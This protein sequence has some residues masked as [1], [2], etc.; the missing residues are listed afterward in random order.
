MWECIVYCKLR[1]LSYTHIDTNR[2]W[3]TCFLLFPPPRFLFFFS[4]NTLYYILPDMILLRHECKTRLQLGSACCEKANNCC[5]NS[6]G[7]GADHSRCQGGKGVQDG[8]G[9]N[10]CKSEAHAKDCYTC[11]GEGKWSKYLFVRV[12][13][14]MRSQVSMSL[15]AI[16]RSLHTY[17]CVCV[18]DQLVTVFFLF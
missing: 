17:M 10:C 16:H 3:Q 7:S 5:D 13:I 1:N 18:R 9:R 11:E 14:F 8:R 15:W 2:R 4:P 6:G 12:Y